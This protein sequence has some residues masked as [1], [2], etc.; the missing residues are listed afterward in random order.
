MVIVFLNELCAAFEAAGPTVSS[1][2]AVKQYLESNPDG[3]LSSLLADQQQHTKLKIISDDILSRFLDSSAYNCTPVRNFLREVL[4]GVVLE[5]T[6]S[7]MSKPESINSWII[8]LFSEGESEIMSAI[9]AGVEGARNLGVTAAKGSEEMAMSA[10]ETANGRST[11]PSSSSQDRGRISGQLDQATEDAMLE[12]NRLN[13][14]IAAQNSPQVADVLN[15]DLQ[16]G[17]T[18]L[19]SDSAN[20][21]SNAESF[22]RERSDEGV[23]AKTG[24]AEGTLESQGIPGHDQSGGLLS[25]PP[26]HSPGIPAKSFSEAPDIAPVFTLHRASITVDDSLDSQNGVSLRSKP[27]SEYLIQVEPQFGRSSGW[28]VFKKYAD[29]ESI[30]ETL[31]TIARLNQLRFGDSHPIV[32]SW[33]GQTRQS[34]ARELGRY[35]QDA[36]QLEPLAGSVTMKRFLEKDRALA[37][38][39]AESTGKSDFHFPGQTAFENV[40]KGVLDVLTNAPKGVSGG[41]KAVLDGVTGVFAGGANKKTSSISSGDQKKSHSVAQSAP[42]LESDYSQVGGKSRMSDDTSNGA[43]ISQLPEL[44]AANGH[45]SPSEVDSFIASPTTP[46]PIPESKEI[47]KHKD[48]ASSEVPSVEE[49]I[50]TSASD[51]EGNNNKSFGPLENKI[52]ASPSASQ[53]G[54]SSPLTRDET[55]MAVELIFAVINELYSLSSAWNIRRTLLNAAKSYILRPGNPSLETIRELLQESM[56]NNQITDEAVGVYLSKLRENALPT[57][58]EL[59]S[60]P[61]ELTTAEKERQRELARRVLIQKGLPQTITSVMGAVASREALGRIFDSLQ[62]Q[63]VARAFVFSILLQALRAVAL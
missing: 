52:S 56:I 58:Q 18:T 6:I 38:E 42:S 43:S 20:A 32:P 46:G 4:G 10:A 26:P 57:A 34:L 55:Q 51:S 49:S 31:G 39:H 33:K 30:H 36:L 27:T 2:D 28:M 47:N 1:E 19:Y 21:H 9:D 41:G 5:S 15:D 59:S 53:E 7:S 8:Y 13:A 61:S 16:S 17:N 37:T 63:T 54:K 14:M 25:S 40:G 45:S 3:S 24:P 44:R 12:A 11:Q 50:S 23:L 48:R 29:F 35:L 22:A 62:V 60:W